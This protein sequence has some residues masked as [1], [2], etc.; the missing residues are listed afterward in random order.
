MLRPVS[1]YRRR[2][3][4]WI[5]RYLA[6]KAEKAG[7]RKPRDKKRDLVAEILRSHS[8]PSTMQSEPSSHLG[9]RQ[10]EG[11][12]SYPGPDDTTD[13]GKESGSE[14]EWE[15]YYDA[16]EPRSGRR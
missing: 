8:M 6:N 15:E 11:E 9:T 3:L 16:S 2:E 13:S 5:D 12:T 10:S 14:T 4:E 7:R 1:P